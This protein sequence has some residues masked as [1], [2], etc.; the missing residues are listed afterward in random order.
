MGLVVFFVSI[1]GLDI[2]NVALFP[3]MEPNHQPECY[4]L[5]HAIY[6]WPCEHIPV[7][8]QWGLIFK[9][10]KLSWVSQG[11]VICNTTVLTLMYKY[12]NV[13]NENHGN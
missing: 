6:G 11:D 3:Q 10:I 7:S 1:K 8:I 12:Y 2:E 5:K 13:V 4:N 9:S